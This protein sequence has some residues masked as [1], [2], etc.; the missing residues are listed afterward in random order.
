[1]TR[2]MKLA[3]KELTRLGCTIVGETDQRVVFELVNGKQWVCG[4]QTNRAT[5]LSVIENQRRTHRYETGHLVAS[6]PI[7]HSAPLLELGGYRVS[8]HFRERT[9]LMLGQGITHRDVVKAL[10]TPEVVRHNPDSGRWYYCAGPVVGVV[11]R[12][13]DGMYE[14][15]TLLWE[16]EELFEQYPRPE[17]ES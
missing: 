11:A 10:L 9:V 17:E 2:E 12:A 6:Y 16:T 13:D 14:L 3:K 1:M 8:T 15:V 5:V 4:R 7:A